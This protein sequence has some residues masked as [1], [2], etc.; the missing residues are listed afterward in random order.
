MSFFWSLQENEN[1]DEEDEENDADFELEIEEVLESDLDENTRDKT[2]EQEYEAVGRR[3]KTRQN[4]HQKDFFKHKKKLLGQ[5][6][7]PLRP[8]LLIGPAPSF[9]FFDG[10]SLM[11]KNAPQCLLS[12]ANNGPVNGFSPHQIGQLHGLINEHVQLLIQI[13]SLC[14][15]EPARQQIAS[16]LRGLIQ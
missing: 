6:N 11:P 5:M 10:K 16:E 15:S 12:S 14:V 9:K 1:V 13:F 3:L 7:R 8:L 2:H 4:R